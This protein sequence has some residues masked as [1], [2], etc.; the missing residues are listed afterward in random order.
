MARC[1]LQMRRNLAILKIIIILQVI[2]SESMKKD[3]N[4]WVSCVSNCWFNA[5]WANFSAISCRKQVTC[6]VM[7]IIINEREYQKGNR[8]LTIRR[9]WQHRAHKTKYEPNKDTIYV[10][11]HY[12]QTNPNNVIKTW[13]LLQTT[14]GKR[15]GHHNTKTRT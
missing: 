7:M 6:D 15:T 8:K 10:G 13:A 12:A 3:S 4:G 1:L 2:V 14:G 9:N 11:H 5:K